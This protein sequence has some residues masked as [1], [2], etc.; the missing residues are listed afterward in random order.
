VNQP[1]LDAFAEEDM[2][3]GKAPTQR[4]LRD[5][6]GAQCHARWLRRAGLV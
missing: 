3:A 1:S 2:I 6:T 5:E 4:T